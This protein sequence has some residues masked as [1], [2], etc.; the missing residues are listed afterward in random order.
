MIFSETLISFSG[1][2]NSRPL[3][4]VLAL[5]Y[6]ACGGAL[7]AYVPFT[8]SVSFLSFSVP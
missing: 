6:F 1:E 7:S 3:R 8:G 4:S 2:G 5:I